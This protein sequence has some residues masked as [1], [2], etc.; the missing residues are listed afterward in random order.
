MVYV[1]Q[2][3]RD[4]ETRRRVPR[5][6]ECV[7]SVARSALFTEARRL[8][9]PPGPRA[10]RALNPG[11]KRYLSKHTHTHTHNGQFTSAP[12]VQTRTAL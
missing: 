8:V 4:G 2:N 1:W 9:S 7:R 12:T 11:S 5:M 10:C 6:V 3:E